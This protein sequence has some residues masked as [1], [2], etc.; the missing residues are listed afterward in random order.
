M[1]PSLG[2]VQGLPHIP[3]QEAETQSQD[4]LLDTASP[5]SPASPAT[6]RAMPPT[7]AMPTSPSGE[8]K[9]GT[10]RNGAPA[11]TLASSFSWPMLHR[12]ASPLESQDE[13]LQGLGKESFW[14]LEEEKPVG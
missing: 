6:P 9:R 1:G 8:R 11:G 7:M 12:C 4:L 2:I 3:W 5:M 10:V 13:G 14:G